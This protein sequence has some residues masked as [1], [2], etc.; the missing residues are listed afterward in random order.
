MLKEGVERREGAQGPLA[1]EEGLY[2][3]KLFSGDPIFLVTPLLMELVCLISLDRF[4]E[5]VR[6][7][8]SCI[9]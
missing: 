2:S 8:K 4:E 6:P 7:K 9:W 3:D 1:R 5:P